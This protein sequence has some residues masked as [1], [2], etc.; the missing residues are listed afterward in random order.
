MSL[1]C[2]IA[3]LS[4]WPH[5]CFP[6]ITLQLSWRPVWASL[7]RS[8]APWL[9]AEP[10]HWSLSPSSANYASLGGSI[11]RQ[12]KSSFLSR[13]INSSHSQILHCGSF[14]SSL[15]SLP[16]PLPSMRWTTRTCVSCGIGPSTTWPSSMVVCS[17]TTT[18]NCACLKSEK[19]RR[20]R[21]PRSA[22]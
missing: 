17:F 10:T 16:V 3:W 22:T 14:L 20:K 21:E 19:W 12:S 5:V 15:L 1:L 8:P 13:Y 7:K 2:I 11:L 4:I 6:Q 18:L 9:F